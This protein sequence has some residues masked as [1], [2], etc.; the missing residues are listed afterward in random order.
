MKGFLEFNENECTNPTNYGLSKSSANRK[1]H[2]P[3]HFH[4]E[5]WEIYISNLTSLMK[6]LEQKEANTSQRRLQNNQTEG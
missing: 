3:Q 2:S 1:V 5:L 4:K 6:S